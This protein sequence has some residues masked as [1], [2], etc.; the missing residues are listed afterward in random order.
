[1]FQ[2]TAAEIY[3]PTYQEWAKVLPR[4]TDLC[5]GAHQDDIEI[6][7]YG[8]ISQCY[9]KDDRHFTGVVVTDGGGSPRSGVYANYSD[10]DM[11]K[12]RVT[13]QK[14]ATH[15]GQY[16]A[17][18]FMAYKSGDV[19]DPANKYLVNEIKELILTCQPEN[20]YTHNLADKHDTHVAV[21]LHVIRALREIP[22]EKRPKKIVSMEVWRGLDWLCDEDKVIHDTGAYPNVASSLVGVFDSQVSGGKRYDLATQGRRLANA[23]FF[24]SHSV[25]DYE[26]ITFGLDITDLINSD[27]NPSD[28]INMYIDRFKDEVTKRVKA[29]S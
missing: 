24:A 20:L 28:F 9:G 3:V 2:N 13:E 26:G 11:K 14:T 12:I 17:Q 6:M 18:V 7:A 23:T 27:T 22:A 10:E 25:D 21:C 15:I 19:K 29:F 5:I 1:M 8:P 16:N 4:T